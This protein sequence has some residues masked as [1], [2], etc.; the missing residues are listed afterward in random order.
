MPAGFSVWILVE[1]PEN[2]SADFSNVIPRAI[3]EQITDGF[4][5]EILIRISEE[6]PVEDFGEIPCEISEGLSKLTPRKI[7]EAFPGWGWEG[8]NA[9][10]H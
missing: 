5:E 9:N 3:P 7:S 8:T 2:I 10:R 6:I 1:I 4:L